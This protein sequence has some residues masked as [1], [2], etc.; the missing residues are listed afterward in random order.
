MKKDQSFEDA[1]LEAAQKVSATLDALGDV[2]IEFS[3]P[4]NNCLTPKQ[5]AHMV[6]KHS[7]TTAALLHLIDCKACGTLFKTYH[8]SKG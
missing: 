6:D 3:T 5:L 8:A 2:L 1:F 7:V 4:T